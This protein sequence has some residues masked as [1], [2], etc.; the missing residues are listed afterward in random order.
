MPATDL[1]AVVTLVN[2][3]SPWL[4]VLQVVPDG[5]MFPEFIPGQYRQSACSGPLHA[6]LPRNGRRFLQTRTS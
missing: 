6:A 1:N 3:I 4:M 5:W 2:R